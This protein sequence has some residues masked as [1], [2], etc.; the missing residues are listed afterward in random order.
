MHSGTRRL[1]PPLASAIAAATLVAAAF[2]GAQAARADIGI[3]GVSRTSGVPGERVDLLLHCGGCL[4]HVVRLPVSL[5]PVGSAPGRHP[6]RDTSCATTAPAPPTKA[7]YI[8]LG[9]A[10][11]LRGGSGPA[12]RLG[13]QI[14]NTVERRGADAV[15]QW[16]ASINRLRFRIP[17]AEPGLYTYVIY[18]CGRARDGD[19]IG[20]PNRRAAANR[21]RIAF[22]REQGE[23]LRILPGAERAA[24][25]G[26]VPWPV[27]ATVASA[28]VLIV[29]GALRRLR[30]HRGAAP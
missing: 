16:V 14:P 27:W 6:C 9:V 13:L 3:E 1:R 18:C 30:A 8:P 28:V 2:L 10:L 11:P 4:P 24:E 5:L 17:D 23:F 21:A 7:P 29:L 26:G 15:G 25:A 19:L 12:S 22:A 20:H